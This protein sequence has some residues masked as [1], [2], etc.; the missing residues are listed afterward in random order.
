MARQV[1]SHQGFITAFMSSI[2]Y[3]PIYGQEAL[4]SAAARALRMKEQNAQEGLRGGKVLLI[5]GATDSVIHAKE[6]Q[7]NARAVL[8]D[9]L[10]EFII[11]DAGHEVVITKAKEIVTEVVGFWKD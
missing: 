9:D 1:A 3:A 5:L 2:R 4:W 11:M 10:V 8:G 7:A 6:L